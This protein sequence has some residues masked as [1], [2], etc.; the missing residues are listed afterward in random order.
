MVS[1]FTILKTLR[2]LSLRYSANFR[3]SRL[4]KQ[5]AGKTN[6]VKGTLK[7]YYFDNP[8]KQMILIQTFELI[9]LFTKGARIQCSLICPVLQT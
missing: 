3:R 1:P 8:I 2:C 5:L 4:V 7:V 9:G 6:Y